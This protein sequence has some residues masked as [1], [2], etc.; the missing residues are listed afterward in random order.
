MSNALRINPK[1][2]HLR[3][4]IASLPT[5]FE[6]EGTYIYGGRRNLIKCF[7]APDGTVVNVKRFC[8]PRLFNRLVYSYGIRQPKGQ[9]AF[10]YPARLLDKGIETP[11]AVAY[12]EE[13][14]V[15]GLLG[16]CY[17][18]SIQCSYAHRL[19]EMQQATPSVY[20]PLAE[21]LAVYTANM[22]NQGVLHLDFSPG[23]VLWDIVD[24]H[25]RFSVVD[26]NRMHFGMVSMEKGCK[27]FARL[28]GPK[29][30]MQL[31]VR[32]YAMLRD[33][34]P[35]QAETILMCERKAFWMRYQKK[36]TLEFEPEL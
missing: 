16:Q 27:S 9:R 19:Y 17:F 26:I 18:V 1:Y 25:Y 3:N 32:R 21:A 31:L 4:Y 2:A 36:H 10:D 7:T 13:R 11:E 33:F 28:W 30:F 34:N 14:N 20:E 5:F 35:D 15:L 22:H 12:I 8:Q 6:D 29:R 24:G 23:N